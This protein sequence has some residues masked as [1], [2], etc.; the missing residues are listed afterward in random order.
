MS[1]FNTKEKKKKKKVDP[2]ASFALELTRSS[3]EIEN[4]ERGRDA[5]LSDVMSSSDEEKS[6]VAAII[7]SITQQ[8]Q[9][10]AK[11]DF[12]D[13]VHYKRFQVT[14]NVRCIRDRDD[15]VI[16][17]PSGDTYDGQFLDTASSSDLSTLMKHGKGKYKYANGDQYVGDWQFDKWYVV[18]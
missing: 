14:N 17:Y 4:F 1:I 16:K 12:S 2:H 7:Q 10:V 15:Q 8:H 11:R 6:T 5:F 9:Q 13:T 3:A 18:M